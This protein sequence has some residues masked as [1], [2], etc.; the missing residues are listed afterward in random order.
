MFFRYTKF[1]KLFSLLILLSFLLV[2]TSPAFAGNSEKRI[3][4]LEYQLKKVKRELRQV[5]NMSENN[6]L[7]EIER[8]LSILAEEFKKVKAE[9][10]GGSV[11]IELKEVF[12]GAPGASKIYLKPGKGLSIG[13]YGEL[14]V[15]KIPDEGD[16]VVDAQRVILYAGYKFT[17]N[18]FFNSEIEFEHGSTGGNSASPE[19]GDGSA[20][21]EFAYLDFLI[22]D[23]F[24][25]RGGLLLVPFGLINEIH[26]PT[27]FYGVFRP[28]V[29]SKIIPTTWREN[30]LGLHGEFNL[31]SIGDISYRAFIMNST[32]S[33]GFR[34]KDNRDLRTR[35]DRSRFNDVAF[36]GR[37]E[38]DPYPGITIGGS[39]FFGNTGQDQTVNTGT[40]T[41]PVPEEING[42]FTMYEL[43][44]NFK[45]RGFHLRTLAVWTSLDDA[46]LINMIN[47]YKGNASVG[48]EQFG[49]Y[50]T[51]AYNVLTEVETRSKYLKDIT[52]FFRFETY[53]TQKSVPTGFERNL[54]NDRTEY[55]IGVN[56]KPIPNMVVKADYQ[57]LNNEANS[58]NNQFNFG[59]GYVF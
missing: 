19:P 41:A 34:A 43:D 42:K 15:S 7:G 36:V 44:A 48:E 24:N 22:N 49:Y 50:V 46:D 23:Y 38:Y 40:D 39:V 33:R 27:G 59:M 13:G 32:D 52:P 31:Q 12:G 18:I 26:E 10:A 55:T 14:V 30:G 3:K 37:L 17:E 25:V 6:R 35:G 58:D 5:K 8:N 57:W 29:E 47:E 1:F 16:N 11:D 20:S 53:D 21:V 54:K 51:I 28:S 9:T 56:Y 2:D 4:N 45:Y